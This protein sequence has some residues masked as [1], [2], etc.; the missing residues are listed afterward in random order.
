MVA[1]WAGVSADAVSG[2]LGVLIGG[3]PVTVAQAWKGEAD[4]RHQ[5]RLAA[6]DR[7]LETH[8]QVFALY[9]ELIL[10]VHNDQTIGEI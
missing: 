10:N 1:A 3:A 5:L 9:R 6:I 8:R 7:R 2:F 4:R